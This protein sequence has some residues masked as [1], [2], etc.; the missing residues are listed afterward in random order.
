MPKTF[1][2]ISK[3][4][5]FRAKAESSFTFRFSSR[6]PRRNGP[7]ARLRAKT[8]A[9]NRSSARSSAVST[10]SLATPFEESFCAMIRFDLPPRTAERVLTAA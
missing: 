4:N 3:L 7:K 2:P 10:I 8:T 1:L 5:P 6:S 9:A